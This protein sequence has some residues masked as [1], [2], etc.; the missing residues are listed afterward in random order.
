MGR[1]LGVI[2]FVAA[3]A[4]VA[5]YCALRPTIAR[6]DVLAA[7]LM[8]SNPSITKMDCDKQVPI[9][10]SG[11][12]F[13]CNVAFRIGETARVTFKLSRTGKIEVT[14]TVSGQQIKKTSDPWD[15]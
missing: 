2:L 14:K 3:V 6:G 9:T 4:G 5:V 15:D 11:A 8:T 12:E 10:K 1:S 13:S 7:E